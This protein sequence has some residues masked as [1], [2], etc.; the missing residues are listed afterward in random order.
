MVTAVLIIIILYFLSYNP[1]KQK[2]GF[3]RKFYHIILT[4]QCSFEPGKN[5]IVAICGN[6]PSGYYFQ[7]GSANSL[8]YTNHDFKTKK[9][10]TFPIKI[11]DFLNSNFTTYVDSP[12][13]YIFLH[14]TNKI[15]IYN[16]SNR[17]HSVV[18][19]PCSIYTRETITSPS[20]IIIRGFDNSHPKYQSFIKADILHNV[21][22]AKSF[23]TESEDAGFSTDGLLQHDTASGIVTYMFFYKNGI[24]CTDTGIHVSYLIPTIDTI[25]SSRV[26]FGR[27]VSKDKTH[28]A[29][30]NLSPL[31]FVNLECSQHKGLLY[32]S[33]ALKADNENLSD[34]KNNSVID[35]YSLKL[36]KYEGSFYLPSYKG[37]K[38]FRFKVF[39]D[40]I[41]AIYKNYVASYS[42]S[43]NIESL[44]N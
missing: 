30:S 5:D 21:F 29:Y 1:Y 41:V 39:D 12:S 33:S 34:F 38:V 11:N 4:R 36:K 32:I 35:V 19:L 28:I 20:N 7:T 40:T 9:Q 2:N 23:F 43:Q 18:Q 22:D 26:Q 44:L 6:T 15:V 24:Y 37:E 31:I 13:I 8:I 27:T 25:R 14:N 42:L 17:K 10:V 3:N 16:I